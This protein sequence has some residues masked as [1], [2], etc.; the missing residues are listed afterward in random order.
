MEE[1]NVQEVFVV[2]TILE[3]HLVGS[4]SGDDISAKSLGQSVLPSSLNA[5]Q[6]MKPLFVTARE[7]DS[8]EECQRLIDHNHLGYLPIVDEQGHLC[9]IYK[10]QDI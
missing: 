6:C 10:A 2:D 8:L 9:G 3:K 5:E 1:K 4:I 7:N